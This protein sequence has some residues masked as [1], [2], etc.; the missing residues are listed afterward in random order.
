LRQEIAM[1][2]RIVTFALMS[3][4]AAPSAWAQTTK[5]KTDA[6][7]AAIGRAAIGKLAIDGSIATIIG[8]TGGQHQDTHSIGFVPSGARVRVTFQSGDGIDPMATLV[9]LQ[10]GSGV[11]SNVRASYAFDDDSGGGRDPRV[12]LTAPYNG[13][14]MLHIGSYDGAFGCYGAKVEILL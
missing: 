10:M 4:L 12:E 11:P 3:V 6:G 1:L 8:C 9:L 5:P 7:S 13:H 2:N 14:V